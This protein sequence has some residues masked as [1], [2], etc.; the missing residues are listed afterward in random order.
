MKS[1]KPAGAGSSSN[2][3]TKSLHPAPVELNTDGCSDL[4]RIAHQA[5]FVHISEL[6]SDELRALQERARA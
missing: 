3:T 5:G 6:V 1:D 2:R 4:V